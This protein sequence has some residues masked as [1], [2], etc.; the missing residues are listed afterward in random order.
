MDTLPENR[1]AETPNPQLRALLDKRTRPDGEP[2]PVN[3]QHRDATDCELALHT[4]QPE[5]RDVPERE[6]C[7]TVAW[8]WYKLIFVSLSLLLAIFD[9]VADWLAVKDF[10]IYDGGNLAIALTFFISC[11]TIL[12]FME[13]YNGVLSVRVYGFKKGNRDKVELWREALS[14]SLLLLEDLPVTMI[15]YTA[16]RGKNCKLYQRIFEDSKVARTALLAAF[17]SA[18]WKGVL[19]LKYCLQVVCKENYTPWKKKDS[20]AQPARRRRSS[21]PAPSIQRPN[22]RSRPRPARQISLTWEDRMFCCACVRCRPLRILV[23]TL[24]CLFT[25]YVF[26]TFVREDNIGSKPE[27]HAIPLDEIPGLGADCLSVAYLY[28]AM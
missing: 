8:R 14:F 10:L 24:V 26:L 5:H 3:G 27:C 2:L 22:A 7:A 13:V 19:S 20:N 16:F 12:F 21:L 1:I 17:I 4:G 6:S 25:A 18:I 9:L 23:N 28:D 11:S 15:M